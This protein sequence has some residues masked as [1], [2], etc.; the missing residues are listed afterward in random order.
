MKGKV[1]NNYNFIL[2]QPNLCLRIGMKEMKKKIISIPASVIILIVAVIVFGIVWYNVGQKPVDTSNS[3]EK[4]I[5]IDSGIGTKNIVK[6]LK[7]NNLVRSELATEIYIKLNN[8]NSLKAGKYQLNETMSL[9]E[10]LNVISSGKV[11]DETVKITFPEGKNMRWIANKIAESTKNTEED[12]YS[13]LQD[14][15]YIQ[16]LIQEYWFIDESIMNENIYYPL[17]GYLFP[18][19]YTFENGD[20]SVKDIFSKMLNNTDKILTKYQNQI[21]NS[22]FNVHKILTISS[23]IE[24]EG[25]DSDARAGIASVFYNRLRKNMPLGSDVTTYYAVR[26]EMT[27]SLYVDDINSENAYNTRGPNMNGK[28]PVGPICNPSED[29]IKAALNPAQTNYLYFVADING[30]VYFSENYEGHQQIIQ[31]LQQEG[32]W[33]E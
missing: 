2:F 9:Q 6:I 33:S 26:K 1:E 32:L 25:N 31:K 21:N 12:V 27:E 11:Y 29:A 5:E 10:I 20:I 24:L 23:V 13:L 17:E 15:T 4:I 16:S 28:L 19:T 30:K 14:T 22:G 7:E 18:D 8:I 3:E